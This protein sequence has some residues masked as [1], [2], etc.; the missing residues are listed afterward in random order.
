MKW[1][2]IESAPKDNTE[3][4][5]YWPGDDIHV[6][7]FT[8]E[9]K[10]YRQMDDSKWSAPTFWMPLPPPPTQEEKEKKLVYS[11]IEGGGHHASHRR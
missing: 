6:V 1:K 3:F 9:G 7:A 11:S 2:S 5:G 4:L 8:P 10:C